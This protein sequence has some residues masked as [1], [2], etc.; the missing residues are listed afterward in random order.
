VILLV[1]ETLDVILDE[2]ETD[3]VFNEVN[4][5]AAE[6]LGDSVENTKE[7]VGVWVRD[8]RALIVINGVEES[9]VVLVIESLAIELIV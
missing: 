4:V 8:T 7:T 1:G 5:D 3:F 9:L 2:S 6:E